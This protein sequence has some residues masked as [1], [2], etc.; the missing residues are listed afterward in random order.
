VVQNQPFKGGYTVRHYGG[1]PQVEALLLELNYDLYLEKYAL[2]RDLMP[3][4][5]AGQFEVAQS[6][7]ER[8]FRNL[9]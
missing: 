4:V 9:F 1:S 2:E 6:R 5:S 7:L 3:V 8:V